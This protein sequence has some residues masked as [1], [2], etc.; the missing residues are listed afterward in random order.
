VRVESSVA[1]L[2]VCVAILSVCV[3]ILR[4]CVANFAGLCRRVHGSSGRGRGRGSSFERS[5]R[6]WEQ[7]RAV[8]EV[9]L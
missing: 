1:N 7:F 2:P 8:T 3:A 4:V 5:P 9:F 6:S